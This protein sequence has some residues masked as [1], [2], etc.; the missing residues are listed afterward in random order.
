MVNENCITENKVCERTFKQYIF[1]SIPTN[2]C[3]LYS[4]LIL[5]LHKNRVQ[6]DKIFDMF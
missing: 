3:I 4:A 6:L 5:K 1:N 2:L